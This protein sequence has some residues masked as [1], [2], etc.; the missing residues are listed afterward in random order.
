MATSQRSICY[1]IEETVNIM[2]DF[3]DHS[4]MDVEERMTDKMPH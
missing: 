3:I 1:T 4:D 2:E